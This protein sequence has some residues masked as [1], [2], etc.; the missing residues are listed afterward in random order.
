MSEHLGPCKYGGGEI[1][2]K[3][4]PYYSNWGYLSNMGINHYKERYV[5]LVERGRKLGFLELLWVKI[6]TMGSVAELIL[7]KNILL[8]TTVTF[9]RTVG[10]SK[11]L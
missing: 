8:Y 1:L 5:I 4:L 7:V 11:D 2:W 10:S 3:I 9:H 6:Q